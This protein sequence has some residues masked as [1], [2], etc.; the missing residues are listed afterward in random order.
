MIKMNKPKKLEFRPFSLYVSKDILKKI[1]ERG[2]EEVAFSNEGKWSKNRN[3]RI[4][5]MCVFFS[6][7]ATRE[8]YEHHEIIDGTVIRALKPYGVAPISDN[9]L[10]E[11]L[12][13]NHIELGKRRK[14]TDVLKDIIGWEFR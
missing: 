8:T 9:Q 2:Y 11:R 4:A 1:F 5:R 14:I 10:E 6:K 12:K 3:E 7:D 13:L